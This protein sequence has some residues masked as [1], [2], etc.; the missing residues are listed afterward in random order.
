MEI[1]KQ[2]GFRIRLLGNSLVAKLEESFEGKARTEEGE[3]KKGAARSK[4]EI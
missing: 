2:A 1:A 3:P 4:A